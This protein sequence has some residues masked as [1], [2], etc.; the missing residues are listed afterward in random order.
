MDMLN[1]TY[2]AQTLRDVRNTLDNVIAH[3]RAEDGG[4]HDCPDCL[5][6]LA[7]IRTQAEDA[8]TDPLE[9]EFLLAIDLDGMMGSPTMKTTWDVADAL[10]TQVLPALALDQT[11]GAVI[12]PDGKEVGRWMLTAPE[13]NEE[14]A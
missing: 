1:P 9:D 10:R 5:R 14:A 8:L 6:E 2:L 3:M 13:E 7:E 4:D 11:E 12:A